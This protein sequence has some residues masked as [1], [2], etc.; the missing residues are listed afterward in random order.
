MPSRHL[1]RQ[2]L[3]NGMW[4]AR[5]RVSVSR[6]R[7]SVV[8]TE[9]TARLK[10]R[11]PVCA[12]AWYVFVLTALGPL[13]PRAVFGQSA[14]L[15]LLEQRAV[16]DGTMCIYGRGEFRVA[17]KERVGATCEST[18]VVPSMPSRIPQPPLSS[19][20]RNAAKVTGYLLG[21]LGRP[22]ATLCVYAVEGKNYQ[23]EV[24]PNNPCPPTLTLRRTR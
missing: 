22:W 11:W 23:M 10:R 20:S 5:L 2:P 18:T 8:H 17:R 16:R 9:P 3:H 4:V 1:T 13:C 24:K 6:M 21:S 19:R 12:L 15:D 7:E 14:V